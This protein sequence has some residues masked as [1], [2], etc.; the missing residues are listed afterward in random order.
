MHGSSFSTS[1]AAIDPDKQSNDSDKEMQANSRP[2]QCGVCT[3][4]LDLCLWHSR[5]CLRSE[6]C[7]QCDGQL[8]V[9]RRVAEQPSIQV[10]ESGSA[11]AVSD[12]DFNN[13]QDPFG[14]DLTPL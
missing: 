11:S 9:R 13:E 5:E 8:A 2:K 10:S 7:L 14:F 6:L 1:S 3:S 4:A 12:A